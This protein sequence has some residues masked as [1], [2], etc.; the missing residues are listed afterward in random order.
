MANTYTQIHLHV[1]FAVQN[2]TCLIQ[3]EWQEELFKYICGI[4]TNHKIQGLN[5]Y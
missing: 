3:K 1:I 2:R 5:W 4:I